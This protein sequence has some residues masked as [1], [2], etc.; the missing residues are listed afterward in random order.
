[1]SYDIFVQ[2]IPSSVQCVEDV[3][4]DFCP[5]S[6]GRRSEIAA[7][8]TAVAPEV[9][10]SD[11]SWGIIEGGGWSI[12]VS[13]GQEEEVLGFAFHLRGSGEEPLSVIAE[14][15]R[16]LKL[17]AFAPGSDTGLFEPGPD[18]SGAFQKW[19]RYRDQAIRR[20]GPSS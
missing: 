20:S 7:V 19:Q 4:E 1:M 9:D 3:P 18:V 14:I 16:R 8:I 17:R 10:F 5:E 2:D 6:V 13:L 12:E 11:P 15:L